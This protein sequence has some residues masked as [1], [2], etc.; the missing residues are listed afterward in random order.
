MST[1]RVP[2]AVDR[3]LREQLAEFRTRLNAAD[4]QPGAVARRRGIPLLQWDLV[5]GCAAAVVLAA[6]LALLLPTQHGLA[7]VAH[8]MLDQPWIHQRIEE[9]G[10]RVSELWYSPTRDILASRRPDSVRFEDHRLRVYYSYDPAEQVVYRGPVVWRSQAGGY[11]SM[12]AAIKVL[13]QSERT[14]D[15]PLDHLGF[16]GPE[17]EKMKVLDQN[18]QKVTEQ[19]CV[20]LDYRLTVSHSG[21]N[22]PMKMLFRVN[23]TTKLPELCCTE[24]PELCRTEGQ[25]DGKPVTIETHFDFPEK[26]PAD[27]YDLGVPRTARF[28][29]RVPSGDLD[30]IWKTLQAGRQRMDNY[31]AIFVMRLDGTDYAWWTERPM[32]FYRKDSK[33]RA[34]YVATWTG[35]LSDVKRPAEGKNLG[36]W[37]A[38]R[39]KFFRF[40]PQYVLRDSMLFTSELKVVTDRDGSEHQDI[41]SVQKS[42]QNNDP[43]ETFPPEYSMRPE[44]AC[45]PPMGLGNPDM[46]PV[47]DMHPAEGPPGCILV[48]IRH[49]STKGRINEKGCGMPDALRYWL[50][51]QRDYIAMRWDM[52][53]RDEKG[54]EAI[55][56]SDTLE[57]T[58]RSPQGVWY[59]T[60]I[61]RSFPSRARNGNFGDQVYQLYVD[62]NADLPDALFE[63]QTPRRIH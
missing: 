17:R 1:R 8:A 32:V 22:Q 10:G 2:A 36:V 62:F 55:F 9:A 18:V 12:V 5:A 41:V 56:E 26:G 61:R 38:E 20:W 3:R 40:Y 51:P 14:I 7:E 46:E 59:A 33:F 34:D 23:A 60:R 63:P 16:L 25:W 15:R 54:Q 19:G 37:W 31:R 35:N 13:L 42:R 47:I 30:R 53:T 58:A 27:I 29:D 21:S 49:T 4:A 45:R 44:F 57:E 11:D 52:L 6:A 28:V 43:G 39:I 24:L 48:H 50:D